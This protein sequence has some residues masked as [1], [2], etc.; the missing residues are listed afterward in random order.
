MQGK[1]FPVLSSF[2]L[3]FVC[4]GMDVFGFIPE[5]LQFH[6]FY[7]LGTFSVVPFEQSIL[8]VSSGL[9]YTCCS[10]DMAWTFQS[11]PSMGFRILSVLSMGSVCS[12]C[13]YCLCCSR[14]PWVPE[15]KRSSSLNLQ[16]IWLHKHC[17]LGSC[18][19]IL[20]LTDSPACAALLWN[21]D[22]GVWIPMIIL[23]YSRISFFKIGFPVSLLQTLPFVNTWSPWLSL[24]LW[25][26][27]NQM[28]Q[29]LCH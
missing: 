22:G 8:S 6:V 20:K 2:F 24:M 18:S 17:L 4:L 12:F 21:P 16:S 5:S 14:R 29:S 13:L 26:T 10:V 7:Y 1:E 11:R 15:L 28:F 27:W 25:E 19:P 3:T 9:P 23:L